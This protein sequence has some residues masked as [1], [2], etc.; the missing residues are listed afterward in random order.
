M[1]RFLDLE[2]LDD[3][4]LERV[5]DRARDLRLHPVGQGL[6]GRTV[7]L[8]FLNPSVRTLASMQAAVTQQGGQVFVITPGAGSWV[9][10]TRDGAVMDGPAAE[11]V[12]EAIPVLAEYADLLAVR[13]FARGEDLAEDLADDL[14]RKMADLCPK[15]FIN[16]E[17]ASAH[18]C[19]ALGDWRT[20]EDLEVPRNGRLVLSWA[21]HPK[22][23]PYAVP[24][25]T[26][27]MAARRGM[28]VTVLHPPGYE[29]PPS[30][31][32][33]ARA[34]AARSGGTVRETVDRR[35]AME[36]AHVLYGKSWAAPSC[37]G[38]PEADQRMRAPLRQEWCIRE[39]WFANSRPEA[40][41]LHCLPVRRNVKVADEVLDGPRSAVVHQAGNRLH[42]QKALLLEMLGGCR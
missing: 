7:G 6:A 25:S 8:L 10:E 19:Q 22:P 13:C 35:E 34:L 14:I 2:D 41:F 5:L 40:R 36:G 33:E 15:P 28:E 21:W 3:Q 16:L 29:L 23:L 9:M 1:R 11:H 27:R 42:A 20:L 37:Y 39:S 18:P 24:A 30:V 4:R 32:E 17:S 38:D 26:L 31:M 12:R